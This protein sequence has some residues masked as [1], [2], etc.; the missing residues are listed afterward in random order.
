M[1][2]QSVSAAFTTDKVQQTKEFYIKHL[3]ATLTFDCG[4]YIN[5][6]FGEERRSL[7]FMSPQVPSQKLSVSDGLT[8]NFAVPDV[9]AVYEKLTSAGLSPTV[10][11]E[12]HPWGDRGFG[13]KDPNGIT[14]YFYTEIEP[15]DAFKA[16]F[17]K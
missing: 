8:Y 10:P 17:I 4:W 14:L 16:F 9:N 2:I 11:L 1:N 3:D 15:D 13:I 7:Q 5:L 12:D 6:V